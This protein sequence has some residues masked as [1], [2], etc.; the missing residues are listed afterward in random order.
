MKVIGLISGTSMD[1]ITAAL[2]DISGED[3]LKVDLLQYKTKPYPDELK[4]LLMNL[5]EGGNVESLCRANFKV[6]E[7]FAKAAQEI[8]ESSGRNP[9]LIGSHGQTVCHL[10]PA[11]DRE[12]TFTLQIG[13]PDVVAERTGIKTVADFRVRD[14][15]AGGGGAPLIPYVDFKLFQSDCTHRAS[16]NLGGI[17]NVTYLPAGGTLDDVIAF[18]TGPANMILDQLVRDLTGGEKEF[19]RGGNMASRGM[20]RDDLLSWL[21]DHPFIE[22]PPPK[23]TGRKHFGKKFSQRVLQKGRELELK[24]RDLLATVTAFS[25]ESLIY[26][27][28]KHLGPIDELI[29][30]GGGTKN[31]ALVGELTDRTD[32]PIKTT[33]NFGIPA[34]AKEALG[35]AILAYETHHGRPSNVPGATGARKL[36]QLGKISPAGGEKSEN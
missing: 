17:A 10:P 4:N 33:G 22:K 3:E 1:G 24:D 21:M 6:G 32:Q 36:V 23:T 15:A 27:M 19:D 16:I 8:I 26:N 20:V 5:T 13:E 31:D 29:I 25:A 9:K 18:D 7:Q 28:D 14:I 34:E 2:V 35:F 12:E 30:A 11:D